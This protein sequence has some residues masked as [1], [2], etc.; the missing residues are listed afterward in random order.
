MIEIKTPY[1]LFTG[2]AENQVQAKTAAGINHF[3]PEKSIGYYSLN[4][5][6]ELFSNLE[7]LSIKAAYE[8][9]AR[10]FIIGVANS[11]GIIPDN[12]LKAILEAITIGFDIASGMHTKLED[13]AIIKEYAQK[14]QVNLYNVRHY[15][16]ELFIGK[17]SNRAGTRILT[18]GTDCSSGKMYSSLVI[19]SALKKKGLEAEFIATGQTGILIKGSGI[20]I[21]AVPADFISGMIEHMS[22]ACNGYQIIEGQGSL[23][24]PSYAGVSLG[25]LHGSQADY[26]IMCHDPL[27]KHIR[28]LADYNLPNILECIETNLNLGKLTNPNIK[29]AGITVN[30]SQMNEV[31][32]VK[33]IEK[34]SEETGFAVTDPCKFGVDNIINNI[35]N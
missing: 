20:S 32:T 16:A 13:I 2:E 15:N 21:D 22:P 7:H 10:T 11:G 25:L 26:I 29:C 6:L 9:G 28:H 4:N 19:E 35:C 14:Y 24:H 33:Y 1:L 30:T 17:G 5:N 8:K 34:L 27:R 23:F 18:V 3:K 31:D 12:W